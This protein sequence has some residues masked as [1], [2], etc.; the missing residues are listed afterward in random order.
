[1]TLGK[2]KGRERVCGEGEG[3]QR[4]EGKEGKER[5]GD[6]WGGRGG[7]EGGKKSEKLGREERRGK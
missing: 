1:M 3:K 7:G 4:E 2:E 5:I 6:F